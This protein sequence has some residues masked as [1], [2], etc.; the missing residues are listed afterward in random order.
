MPPSE[1]RSGPTVQQHRRMHV[2][3]RLAGVTSRADRL[4]LTSALVKRPLVTSSD[5]TQHE[6]YGLITY[7]EGLYRRG[8]LESTAQRW[9]AEHREERNCG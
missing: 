2:L 6:A 4:A 8:Q 5:M 7:M 1:P 3:W 9:L